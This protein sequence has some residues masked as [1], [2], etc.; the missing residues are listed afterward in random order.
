MDLPRRKGSRCTP[1]PE[2]TPVLITHIEDEPETVY[3]QLCAEGLRAGHAGVCHREIG[4][5]HPLLGGR[6]RACPGAGAGQQYLRRAVCRNCKIEDLAEE[7]FLSQLRPGQT[8]KVLGLTPACRGA[9]RRRLL[10]LGFVAGTQVEVEMVSPGGDPTAYRVRGTVIALRREQASLIRVER[11]P[12]PHEG[13]GK[14]TSSNRRRTRR[15]PAR[16]AASIAPP[17]SRNSA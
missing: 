16:A 6:Q 17:I 14:S 10:D 1:S 7:Q 8:A 12:S 5:P 15:K 9:E 13:H 11:V 4:P 2:N 3:A